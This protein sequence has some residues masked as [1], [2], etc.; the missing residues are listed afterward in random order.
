MGKFF[1]LLVCSI[2]LALSRTHLR[3]STL[4]KSRPELCSLPPM[5]PDFGRM[6][7]AYFRMYHW[8]NKRGKCVKYVYGGCGG[9]KNLFHTEQECYDTCNG[10]K[11]IAGEEGAQVLTPSQIKN[12][13]IWIKRRMRGEEGAQVLTPKRRIMGQ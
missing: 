2:S 4:A 5:K 10:G 12:L 7:L 9:T 3:R 13:G 8:D 6:C 1:L 11:S